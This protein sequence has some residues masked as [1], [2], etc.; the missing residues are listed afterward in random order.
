MNGKRDWNKKIDDD[1]SLSDCKKILV[2]QAH[3][4]LMKIYFDEVWHIRCQAQEI[5]LNGRL[6]QGFAL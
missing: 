5:M 4:T 3:F 1:T 6:R 2:S